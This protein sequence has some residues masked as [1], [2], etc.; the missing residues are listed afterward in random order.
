MIGIGLTPE[1]RIRFGHRLDQSSALGLQF[2]L[3]RSSDRNLT[4]RDGD[5]IFPHR[6]GPNRNRSR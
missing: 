5:P 4:T 3:F 1:D 6:P 2:P